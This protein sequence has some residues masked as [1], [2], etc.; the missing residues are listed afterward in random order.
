VQKGRLVGFES[1]DADVSSPMAFSMPQAVSTCAAAVAFDRFQEPPTMMASRFN[2]QRLNS[3]RQKGSEAV[4]TG[5]LSASP[6]IDRHVWR[7]I[8]ML[9]L[10]IARL[11]VKLAAPFSAS[12]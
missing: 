3:A 6:P 9:L 1:L 12:G 2:H 11:Q 4:M 8:D 5:F 10:T 7:C